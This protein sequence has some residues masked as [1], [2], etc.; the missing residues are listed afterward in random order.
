[1]PRSVTFNARTTAAAIN[2]TS[3]WRDEQA[4][5]KIRN[6]KHRVAIDVCMERVHSF[7]P[8]E[9]AQ[10]IHGK[11]I[12][13]SL[14]AMR[15]I[16]LK[17]VW[18]KM[19]E[20]ARTNPP[21]GAGGL[22]IIAETQAWTGARQGS[23]NDFGLAM[24]S[25]MVTEK[26]IQTF[27][28]NR[29]A[30]SPFE[31]LPENS[32][33]FSP[34]CT[35][36]ISFG[37]AEEEVQ[38]W[39]FTGFKDDKNFVP[40]ISIF[41]PGTNGTLYA[42]HDTQ[43][44]FD[45]MYVLGAA[46]FKV[47]QR[48]GLLGVED[49]LADLVIGH[50][51]HTAVFKFEIFLW[52]LNQYKGNFEKALAE[53]KKLCRATI[54]APQNGTVPRTTGEMVGRHYEP[55]Q[56][57]LYGRFGYDPFER[58]N[59]LFIENNLSGESGVVSPVHLEI[60]QAEENAYRRRFAE[61]A[62]KLL[63]ENLDPEK[64]VLFP[65]TI[66]PRSW[67]GMGTQLVLDNY[68]AGWDQ[69]LIERLGK[70]DILDSLRANVD[71]RKDLSQAF[72]LQ[73]EQ[74]LAMLHDHFPRKFGVDIPDNP[75]IFASLRRATSYKLGLTMA[76]LNQAAT[77]DKIARQ[78]GHPVFY[79]FGGLAHQHDSWSINDLE[80]LLNMIEKI[81]KEYDYFKAD[82]LIG[83]D[84]DKARWIFPGLAR[85]GCWVGATNPL[86]NRSQGCEAFGPSYIKSVMN[87]SYAIG[88]HDGGAACMS[89]LPT[90]RVF[91][92]TT[93]AG[94]RSFHNDLWSNSA[95]VKLSNFLLEN[96]FIRTFEEVALL[97][98]EDRL[99]Y[100]LG[101]GEQAPGLDAKII[102]M[103]SAIQRYNGLV[104]MESYLER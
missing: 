102:A 23:A 78:L 73:E 61:G 14:A 63:P 70:P 104:L 99:R 54:H 21:G 41:K 19:Q 2:M 80:K 76:F 29:Q 98:R 103:L 90:V 46:G 65:D 45:Q 47:A 36:G 62:R 83:Y 96:G 4:E 34:L 24:F 44:N 92:L 28:G 71:F 55:E 91:G 1:M 9:L 94:D 42:S 11:N 6:P 50:D 3:Q 97:I 59:G 43:L 17:Q 69:Q 89:D 72:S 60:T 51:G 15:E 85:S 7:H 95:I 100:S 84:Y 79:L 33:L 93:M 10:M 82:F 31:V 67:L 22:G 101:R 25:P 75:I 74:L 77:M 26:R 32:D 87:G 68:L 64:L 8:A 12:V 30:I 37:H 18:G 57:A 13:N 48:F 58:T 5:L 56:E 66:D 39:L 35:V 81:N 27:E 53:T 49:Q 40:S 20:L 16:D 88:A 52:F 86:A 38:A